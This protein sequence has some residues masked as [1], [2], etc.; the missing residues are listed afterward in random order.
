M[1]LRADIVGTRPVASVEATRPAVPVGDTHQEVSQRLNRIALGSFLEGQILSRL[2]D[3]SFVVKVADTA[4]RMN[5]PAGAQVGET[6]DLTL[7][8]RQPR[9]TFL[10]NPQARDNSASLS[11]TGRLLDWIIHTAKASGAPATLVGHA[12]LLTSADAD[13]GT[14][15]AS[16]KDALEF[17]GL[18]YE[19]HLEQWASGKRPLAALTREPQAKNGDLHLLMAALRAAA[20]NAQE[21]G[22]APHSSAAQLARLL[23][24]LGSHPEAMRSPAP[25]PDAAQHPQAGSP[26]QGARELAQPATPAAPAGNAAT[27]EPTDAAQAASPSTGAAGSTDAAAGGQPPGEALALQKAMSSESVNMINLQ[28]NALEQQRIAWRGE[29][30]PGLQIEWEIGDETPQGRQAEPQERVWQSVIRFELPTLGKISATVRLAD[31]RVQIQVRAASEETALLLR[32][33]G[34]AL[35]SALAAAGSPLERLSVQR[36]DKDKTA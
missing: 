30:W 6:V 21:P 9:P 8:A 2:Q 19:S 29:L 20:N 35:S 14:I 32:A 28:L 34:G 33:H 26:A 11:S 31:E 5:L 3:G 25:A 18:F 15:A 10:L 36:D 12:P 17:S 1:L 24:N 13:A 22:G 23:E 16:M 4:L 27:P 7:V